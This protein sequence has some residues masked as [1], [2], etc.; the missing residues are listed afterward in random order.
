MAI[1]SRALAFASRWFDEATVR[2]V[3]EPLIADWQREWQD[4]PLGRR[5]RV[6]MRGLLAFVLAVI[7]SS[8]RIVLT[9]A[10]REV[11]RLV[12]V[13]MAKFMAIATAILMLPP[14]IEISTWMM[15]GA[16]WT[17]SSLFFFA[18]PAAMTLAFPFA[19][20][21]AVDALRRHHSM[22]A[23]VA[24][25]AALKLGAFAFAVMLVYS[26]WVVPA[27]NRAA[28][29]AMNPAG[30]SEPLRMMRELTTYELVSDPARASVFD[31]GTY[32]ASRS[33]SLTRE[34]N[35]RAALMALPIVLL[36]LRWR[37]LGRPSKRW[38]T[39]LPP[40]AAAMIAI[41]VLFASG[42][43]GA[44]LEREWHLWIG[45]SAWLPIAAFIGWGI[46]TRYCR[47]LLLA[48]V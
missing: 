48:R 25:A 42:Y 17:R 39:P 37:A 34:L 16:S 9:R 19:M 41:A 12:A 22:P 18:V 26:G 31:R 8:P 30:M 44:W 35:Q 4:A 33:Q 1:T 20:T 6:S 45:T 38:V 27:A 47:P 43:S 24:R 10:P 3:F 40:A 7:V 13:R 32:L 46:V 11:T 15:R 2:R 29:I 36:W 5:I 28:R 23:H 14:V 21:G